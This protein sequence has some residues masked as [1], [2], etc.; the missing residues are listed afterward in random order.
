MPERRRILEIGFGGSPAV[1]SGGTLFNNPSTK[2]V[3]LDLMKR[4][5]WRG[6]HMLTDE[7]QESLNTVDETLKYLKNND[8]AHSSAVF[9][10]GSVRNLPFPNQTFS[11][12]VM[13]SV[14]G[15][16]KESPR[17]WVAHIDSVRG[18]GLQ[19][20]FRVLEPGG[21]IV[22]LEENTPWDSELTKSYLKSVGFRIMAFAF[23]ESAFENLEESSKW[24]KLRK[25]Y[26][27]I[28]PNHGPSYMLD[29][30]YIVIGQKPK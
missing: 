13:R 3:G 18:E 1:I 28:P 24:K 5:D 4:N 16:F 29:S 12:I 26:F 25:P 19:E 11:A 6:N 8:V 22:I 30:P 23:M 7:R 9:V 21:K 10:Q 15:Q 14:F 2:Y 20:S 27:K 17:I